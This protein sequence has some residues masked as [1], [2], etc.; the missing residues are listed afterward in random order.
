MLLTAV[1]VVSVGA[2]THVTDQQQ[3]GKHLAQPLHCQDGWIISHVSWSTP[4]ILTHTHTHS[5]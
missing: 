5:T 4:P 1:S 2:E 3:I